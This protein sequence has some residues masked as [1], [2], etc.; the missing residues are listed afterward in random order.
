VGWNWAL[1]I[2]RRGHQVWV[3]T[4]SNNR[5]AIELA[6]SQGK[7]SEFEN[8]HFIYYD[9]PRWARWWKKGGRGV[10][11]YYAMWQRGAINIAAVAHRHYRFDLAHHITFGVWRQ[12]SYL[13][14]LDIPVIFGPVGGGE[15]GTKPLVQS[16]PLRNRIFENIRGLFNWLALFN[17]FLRLSL[18]QAMA[19]SKTPETSVW[20]ERAGGTGHIS[21][22]IGIDASAFSYGTS[23]R[24]SIGFRCLFAGRLLGWK[25]V[26]FALMAIAGAAK[27]GRVVSL[28]IVGK[29][30]MKS[31]LHKMARTLGIGERVKFI[32]WLD[33]QQLFQQY[34]EHDVLLFPSLHDSSG[35]VILEAFAHGLP[36]VC[37]NLGGPGVLV[38]D[39]CGRAI[40]VIGDGVDSAS[41][42]LAG[43]LIE[44]VDSPALCASLGQGARRKSE[45]CTWDA[46]VATIYDKVEQ[47]F[48]ADFSRSGLVN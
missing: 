35:N 37:F 23:K 27:Q 6:I 1:A 22:E 18:K 45:V 48:F 29:G 36:V 32:D 41:A 38:D 13:Y 34:R 2:A 42:K 40:D 46:S 31:M 43:A 24:N 25:G 14:K 47:E 17:P 9:V 7:Q 20:V 3:L 21:M 15:S 30:P 39:T 10:H 5:A 16:L 26:H 44:L 8:L 19:F 11:L 28:T 33:Q 12:P 4:R